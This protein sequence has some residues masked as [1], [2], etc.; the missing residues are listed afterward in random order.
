M[1]LLITAIATFLSSSGLW[2]FL[3]HRDSKLNARVSLLVGIGYY[4]IQTECI[5]HLE[6]GHITREE[7]NDIYQ[8]LYV[9]YADLGGNGMAK[10]MMSDVGNLPIQPPPLSRYRPDPPH[11]E[12]L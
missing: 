6:K 8:H 7:Y 11:P 10:K 2:A 5:R 3:Q 12:E 9:P 4:A 1:P